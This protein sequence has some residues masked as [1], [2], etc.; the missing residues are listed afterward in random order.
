M[1]CDLPDDLGSRSGGFDAGNWVC[2]LSIALCEGFDLNVSAGGLPF[3]VLLER[4]SAN[5]RTIE[6]SFG[7]MPTTSA[8]RLTSLF[9]VQAR[10]GL[11]ECCFFRCCLGKVI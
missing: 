8:Q 11:V 3:V 9:K 1:R 7:T 5:G 10:D 6:A 4:P 2:F